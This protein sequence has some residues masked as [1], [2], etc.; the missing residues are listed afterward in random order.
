VEPRDLVGAR[1]GDLLR[2]V[3]RERLFGVM[4]EAYLGGIRR[5]LECELVGERGP[6]DVEVEVE[7]SR[8]AQGIER[9]VL[10]CQPNRTWQQTS[11]WARAELRSWAV[12]HALRAGEFDLDY[13]PIVAVATRATVGYEAL[14]RWARPGV[15]RIPASEFLPA[16]ES[17]GL[18][19]RLSREVLERAVERLAAWAPSNP[20]HELSVNVSPADIV[21]PGY[22]NDVAGAVANAGIDPRRLVLEFASRP[23]RS[24]PEELAQAMARLQ[25]I[26]GVR[27]AI[28]D[29]GAPGAGAPANALPIDV[30]KFDRSVTVAATRSAEHR[31]LLGS[32]VSMVRSSG[33]TVIGTGVESD[34]Q[35]E[36]LAAI[37]CEYA[38]GYLLGQP[39]PIEVEPEPIVLPTEP[40]APVRSSPWPRSRIH[41]IP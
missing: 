30:L 33:R 15:G 38:Q 37:G 19:T 14:V 16:V 5:R 24:D 9:W 7:A 8:T 40:S 29:Y 25:R 21:R 10:R 32:L 2:R 41:S 26:V 18:M 35:V 39:S 20:W 34:E 3:D 4:R 17:A 28:D 1:I 27:L 11:A 12:E 13:Q 31:M 6:V 22:A 36:A 23:L